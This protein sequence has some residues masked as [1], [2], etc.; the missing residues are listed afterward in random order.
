MKKNL[1][2]M[3]A[4]LAALLLVLA[5][6]GDSDDSA[7][8]TSETTE[9]GPPDDRDSESRSGRSEATSRNTTSTAASGS[10]LTTIA[11]ADTTE[12]AD[13]ADEAASEVEVEVGDFERTSRDST[14]TFG[15]DVDTASLSITRQWIDSGQ[16]PPADMVR[17]E[18]FVNSFDQ[19]YDAPSRDTFA[20][21]ADGAPHDL[22]DDNT[23]VLRIGIKGEEVSARRRADANLT[24]VIDVSGSMESDH[25]LDIVKDSL[26]VLI[27][28]LDRDDRIAIVVYDDRAWVHLDPTFVDDEET[29]HDAIDD[30][31]TGGSTNAEAGLR[32]GYELARDTFDEGLI[33]QVVFASDGV[34]NVGETDPDG[35]LAEISEDAGRGIQMLAIGVGFGQFNDDLLEHIADAGNGKYAYIDTVEEARRLFDDQL[36]STLVTVALDAKIQVDFDAE[37][38]R[39]WRLIGFENREM[40]DREFDNEGTDAGEIGAGHSVTALY[41]VDLV[42]GADD[43]DELGTVTLRWIDPDTLDSHELK[44]VVRVDVLSERLGSASTH[45]RWDIAVATAA[46]LLRGSPW[47][48]HVSPREVLDELDA[49]ANDLDSDAAYDFSDMFAEAIDLGL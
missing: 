43:R 34:A 20:I 16:L 45:L 26:H 35:I 47:A 46:E 22:I 27:D 32:L 17:V 18:E 39:S 41:E 6:C 10:T 19:D 42:R 13:T 8:S 25:K 12:A 30:L 40:S 29:I 21:Y 5:A 36:L 49:V 2:Q 23:I 4:V 38:V 1:I 24:F 7:D 37:V 33:N 3:L 31:T 11:T 48:D 14:S 9:I 15:L 44:G 28:N